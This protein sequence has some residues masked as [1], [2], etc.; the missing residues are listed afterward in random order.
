MFCDSFTRF[1]L[2]IRNYKKKL[3][4]LSSIICLLNEI[5][6]RGDILYEKDDSTLECESLGLN[7][8]NMFYTINNSSKFNNRGSLHT[9]NGK[10]KRRR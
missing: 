9:L 6:L 5:F 2:I 3:E 8:G 10:F 1:E 4:E 7:E